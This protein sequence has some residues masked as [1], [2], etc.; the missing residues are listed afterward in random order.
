MEAFGI[1]LI[2]GLVVVVFVLP[3][4]AFVRSG[5]AAREAGR[6][7]ARLT[8]LEFELERLKKTQEQ[9][10]TALKT[11]VEQKFSA[12]A[13]QPEPRPAEQSESGRPRETLEQPA[14]RPAS[15]PGP[16]QP[17]FVSIPEVPPAFPEPPPIFEPPV[18][19]PLIPPAS[20][21]QAAFNLEKLKG[22]LNWEQF[23]GA[24]LFAW[25]GGLAL[26]L[27][28]AYFV[29]FSFEHDLIPPEIRVA[30]GFLVGIGLVVAGTLMRRKQYAITA[31]TF[32]A[33]GIVILYAV[34]FA[35][36]AVYHFPFFGPVPTFALM[37]LVTAAAFL[38][39][40]R[41]EAQVV[42]LLGML[43]GFLTPVLLSTGQD[44][45]VAL[46]GYIALLDAGLLAVALYRRWFYLTSLAAAGTVFM[47]LG[48]AAKFFESEQYFLGNKVLI[49]MG[50]LLFFNGLWLGATRLARKRKEDDWFT[51]ISTTA[52]AAVAFAF[53][54]Y[55]VSFESLGARP[56]LVFTFGFMVDAGVLLLTRLDRRV[57]VAQPLA[58]VVI[59]VLLAVWLGTRVTNEL[60]PAALGFT[61]VFAA[62]HSLLPLAL[63]RRDGDPRS[64]KELLLF[65]PAALLVLLVPIFKLA[66]LT[67]LI[68]PVIL[69]VD[70]LAV[71][72]AAL[73]ASALPVLV[74]LVLTLM[75]AAGVLFKIPSELA[76]LPTL[77]LV[78][79]AC[80]I[81]FAAAGAW[82]GRR[83]STR[84]VPGQARGPGDDLATHIPSFAI[85]LPFALLVM[86]VGRLPLADPSPV[87]GLAMLLVALLFAVTWKLGFQWLPLI[88]LG[89]VAALEH[90]WHLRLFTVEAAV[91][92]LTWYLAF[93][94]VFTAFPF[95][96]RRTAQANGPWF[97]SALAGPVQFFLVH[98]LVKAA[99]PNDVMGLLPAGFAVPAFLGLFG[100]LKLAP[101]DG[102]ARLTRLALFG[103]AALFFVT[104][105]FPIQFDRQWLTIAWALEGAA[106][107]WLFHRV[108]HPGLRMTGVALLVV[109]F[110]RLALNP[111]VLSYH[112]RSSTAILNWYLYTYG[113]VTV[114]LFAG[115]RLLAPP[116]E[117]VF[118]IHAPALLCILGTILAFLLVN[119]QIADFFTEPGAAVLAFK[120]SGNFAR[121][122]TY[123][124]AWA[125]FALMLLIAGLTRQ[126]VAARY[127]AL[128]LLGATLLKLFFHDLAKLAQLYRI[129]ALM[130]VAVIAILAS[131]LYQRFN[132]TVAKPDEKS[133]LPP[134][135]Q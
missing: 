103:G 87:F 4:A 114:G 104:L 9:K 19:P 81:F 108:P 59:F 25:I 16:P 62:V 126:I 110:A 51:G 113:S 125:L 41:L 78:V 120:F 60:L 23:M 69:L 74:V 98:Q 70:L 44:A 123:S 54:F 17:P 122:M 36:R 130:G 112:A 99:W 115:A 43:G 46:F 27:G 56:W 40:V 28:V 33:T 90:A 31:H 12:P 72:L 101:A 83:L 71:A 133:S 5:R 96:V 49:P 13:S 3:I 18:L 109:A 93:F 68:W 100:V 134:T 38:L 53:A 30:L 48:W 50:V 91:S 8:T 21:P 124:I 111:A 79:A 106:L 118:T 84:D 55:F 102:S 73:A 14:G 63:Q 86:I 67:V 61:L 131:F 7:H 1:L 116:R 52:L 80:S 45:P 32:C 47:Q 57:A 66:E 121:D 132:A 128:G 82:L 11:S 65:P 117:R 129:G 85:V 6:F 94:F 37:A 22:S 105:I 20:M 2:L 127:A 10:P 97:A 89:C 42:A 88:G 95:V 77:L 64:R 107:C 15:E 76:G 75:A 39:A 135:G 34:T 92:A 35:C 58:G 26:F 119:I 24:K 29:K